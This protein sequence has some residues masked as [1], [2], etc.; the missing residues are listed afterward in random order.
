MLQI[1]LQ[2]NPLVFKSEL[3]GCF[4][5]LRF[6]ILIFDP[7]LQ[8]VVLTFSVHT[9]IRFQIFVTTI[10]FPVEWPNLTSLQPEHHI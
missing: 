4:A 5:Y 9:E 2:H 3:G 8:R 10:F 1:L 7:F 6:P